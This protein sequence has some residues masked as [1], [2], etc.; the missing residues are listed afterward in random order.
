MVDENPFKDLEITASHGG[1]WPFESPI[2]E[3]LFFGIYQHLAHEFVTVETQRTFRTA[4]G[5]F[6]V[7]ILLTLDG[8]YRIAIE[9]DG[10]Y[11]HNELS[12][13]FRDSALLIEESVNEVIRFR[14]RDIVFHPKDCAAILAELIP[15]AFS[16]RG[17]AVCRSVCSEKTRDALEAVAPTR[18]TVVVCFNSPDDRHLRDTV[19]VS[20]NTNDIKNSFAWRERYEFAKQH[21]GLP[22]A[23]IAKLWAIL[24][25]NDVVWD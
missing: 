23:Q 11:F 24:N 19:F 10:R 3:A 22:V 5:N 13:Q 12:D 17:R 2:E 18:R 14:G 21:A 25:G 1:K 9:C 4:V 7:D 16:E 20:R 6:R 8:S 15:L